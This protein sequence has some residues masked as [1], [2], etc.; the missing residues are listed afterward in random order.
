MSTAHITPI[1]P[2]LAP[3]LA[4][5]AAKDTARAE[6][7]DAN[8]SPGVRHGGLDFDRPAPR[9]ARDHIAAAEASLARQKTFTASPQGRFYSAVINIGKAGRYVA[10]ATRALGAY[11]RG[12]S[13]LD[14]PACAAEVGCALSALNDVPGPDGREARQ[15]LAE[16]LMAP[17]AEAA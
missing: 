13:R 11:H 16:I 6:Y 12:F 8:R 7:F 2:E 9:S 17:V 10:E 5:E 15:A 1:R 3:H 4:F 14:R